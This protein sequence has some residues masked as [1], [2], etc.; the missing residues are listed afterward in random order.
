MARR[1]AF[2]PLLLSLNIL[3]ASLAVAQ[4]DSPVLEE[5]L[6]TAS[7][8]Q[9]ELTPAYA[10]GQVARG[11]RAGLLGNLD[12]LEAP[13]SATAYTEALIHGQQA[14]SVG[15]VLEN[16]PMVRTAKGFGNFQ[17]VYIVRGFPVYSDDL[18]LNGLYG[19]LPRQFV[20]AAL[21]WLH[22]RQRASSRACRRPEPPATS[23][24]RKATCPCASG[25]KKL[26]LPPVRPM[27]EL[28]TAASGALSPNHVAASQN[29]CARQ[30]AAHSS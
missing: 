27:H 24:V 7:G 28:R 12:Y 17:E 11:W 29:G 30:S 15:D 19:V 25:S 4:G 22:A 10:G 9:V 14:E 16:D 8:S 18:T 2:F 1:H 20:Q 6:V 21:D 13:F 23:H 26:G 3:P 5:V